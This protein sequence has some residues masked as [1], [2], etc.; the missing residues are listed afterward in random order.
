[1]PRL[2]NNG[3]K[4]CG[5]PLAVSERVDSALLAG[6][7]TLEEIAARFGFSRAGLSRHKR[8]HLNHHHLR[9]FRNRYDGRTKLL[10]GLWP[11]GEYVLQALHHDYQGIAHDAPQ[12]G[13]CVVKSS[14][15]PPTPPREIKNPVLTDTENN[16]E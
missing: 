4:V 15:E 7:D 8:A 12:D 10:F 16:A 3:C 14:F 11:S 2:L 9:A 5:A 1:M 6:T 13:D